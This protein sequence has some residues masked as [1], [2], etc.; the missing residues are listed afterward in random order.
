MHYKRS[1]G[2]AGQRNYFVPTWKALET[3]C[4]RRSVD[5]WP[6]TPPSYPQYYVQLGRHLLGGLYQLLLYSEPRPQRQ[7]KSDCLCVGLSAFPWLWMEQ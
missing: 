7:D 4:E 6:R 2:N 1:T 3:L 5:S